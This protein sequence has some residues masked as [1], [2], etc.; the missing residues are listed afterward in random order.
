MRAVGVL[1]AAGASRRFGPDDKLLAPYRQEPLVTV[2]AQALLAAGCD[3]CTAVVSSRGVAAI[4]P[5]KMQPLFIPAGLPMAASFQ[6]AL[7]YARSAYADK[8]LVCLGDMP[9]VSP[10]HLRRLI[11]QSQSTC[12]ALGQV[13][14]PPV[15]L[16]AADYADAEKAAHGDQGARL[17]LGQLDSMM[18]LSERDAL[19]VDFVDDLTHGEAGPD[20]I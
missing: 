5:E 2:A 10:D 3:A 15:M 1:L 4:L 18:K 8:L 13:R 7:A 16:V 6:H 14:M 11:K 9:N 19:D 17:L 20:W 12:S